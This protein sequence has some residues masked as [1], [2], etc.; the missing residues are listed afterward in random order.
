MQKELITK[1]GLE[2]EPAAERLPIL[3]FWRRVKNV[4][5]GAA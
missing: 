4:L 3:R 1:V 5:R 2:I